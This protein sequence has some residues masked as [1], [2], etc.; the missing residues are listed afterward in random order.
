MI[1]K[2]TS[3]EYEPSSEPLLITVKQ[4]PTP[5]NQVP[6]DFALVPDSPAGCADSLLCKF[7]AGDATPLKVFNPKP[8]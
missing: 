1:Q 3:L 4:I 7:A 5:Q 6:K 8:Y 2:S